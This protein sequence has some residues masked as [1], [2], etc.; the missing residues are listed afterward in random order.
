MKKGLLIIF[1]ILSFGLSAICAYAHSGSLD[2]NGGHYDSLTGE[3]HYHHGYPAHQ[4]IGDKCP[5]NFDDKTNKDY[6]SE[7]EYYSN[8][9]T[10]NSLI[11]KEYTLWE[12][13]KNIVTAVGVSLMLGLLILL[14]FLKQ[15]TT[16]FKGINTSAI[17]DTL[18]YVLSFLC[19]F[20]CTLSSV[21]NIYGF[22]VLLFWPLMFIFMYQWAKKIYR[23]QNK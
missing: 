10:T 16:S 19:P 1:T 2:E 13:V 11:K 8:F 21:Y 20:T 18:L 4:H 12:H 5:Y 6:Y 9:D 15:I 22:Q 14:M 23:N 7:E 17:Y 3:Y